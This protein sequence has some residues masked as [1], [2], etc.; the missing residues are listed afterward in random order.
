MT[1]PSSTTE[2]SITTAAD[3]Y[4]KHPLFDCQAHPKIARI[5]ARSDTVDEVILRMC[6]MFQIDSPSFDKERFIQEASGE[7]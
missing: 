6:I 2:R 4:R 7:T 5:L 1:S 3:L